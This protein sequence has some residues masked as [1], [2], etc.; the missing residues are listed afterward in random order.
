M[1]VPRTLISKLPLH[2]HKENKFPEIDLNEATK[3]DYLTDSYKHIVQRY[4]LLIHIQSQNFIKD[5]DRY[6][7]LPKRNCRTQECNHF[8]ENFTR[9]LQIQNRSRRKGQKTQG[10]HWK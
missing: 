6:S 4:S 2:Y 10:F 1:T 5:I 7:D 8:T 9:E 3:H